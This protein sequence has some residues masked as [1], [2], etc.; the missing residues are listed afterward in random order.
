MLAL[1][2]LAPLEANTKLWRQA[3]KKHLSG[4]VCVCV[5]VWTVGEGA[6]HLTKAPICLFCVD[7]MFAYVGL[8]RIP[9]PL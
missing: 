7:L 2:V 5:C 8:S 9:T 6:F 1:L 3:Q 4:L